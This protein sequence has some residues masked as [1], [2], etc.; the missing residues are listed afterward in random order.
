MIKIESKIESVTKIESK[1]KARK[2]HSAQ[3]KIEWNNVPSLFQGE[4]VLAFLLQLA[5]ASLQ[6]LKTMN[7]SP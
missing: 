5:F 4:F 3:A 7:R 6:K 2:G 1:R